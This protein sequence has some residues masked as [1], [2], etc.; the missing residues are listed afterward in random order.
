MKEVKMIKFYKKNIA[1]IIATIAIIITFKRI[2]DLVYDN[3]WWVGL[4]TVLW[5]AFSYAIDLV[6]KYLWFEYTIDGKF[7]K[8]VNA[9]KIREASEFGQQMDEANKVG[10]LTGNWS[11]FESLSQRKHKQISDQNIRLL[12]QWLKNQLDV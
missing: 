5:L 1:I 12:N 7:E 9:E 4:C 10:T 3:F 2:Q 11:L 6:A 8:A